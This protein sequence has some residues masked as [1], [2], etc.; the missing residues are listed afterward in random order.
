MSGKTTYLRTVA[1]ACVLA[2]A[3]A[4][5]PG[6]RFRLSPLYLFTSIRVTDDAAHGLSTFYAE[7]LRI[8]SMM[9][10]KE[11]EKPMLIVIDEIFKGTNSADRLIGAREAI[12]RLT[13]ERFITLVSTHDFELCDIEST[14]APITNW[15]FEENYE[16]DKIAFDYKIKEGRCTTRNAQYLLKMA[17]IME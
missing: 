7:I 10:F 16:G 15:H 8:K 1:S 17:G 6:E 9:A 4:P 2:Y 12:S 3:G 13:G 11:K 5:V 14:A